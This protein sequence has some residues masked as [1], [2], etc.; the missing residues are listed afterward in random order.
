L[1]EQIINIFNVHSRRIDGKINPMIDNSFQF[2]SKQTKIMD[3]IFG[4][5]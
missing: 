5:H 4:Y 3:T 2:K 1:A